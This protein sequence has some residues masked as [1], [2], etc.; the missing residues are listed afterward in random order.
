MPSLKEAED[1]ANVILHFST[2]TNGELSYRAYRNM[3][4]KVGLPLADLAEE[5]SGVMTTY[6]DLQA[7]PRRH[8]NSPV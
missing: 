6:K 8:I 3:E 2:L 5:N 7:Q 4:K 1:A